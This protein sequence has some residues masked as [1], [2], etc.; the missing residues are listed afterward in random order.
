M[1]DTLIIEWKELS[2]H[3]MGNTPDRDQLAEIW[4]RKF[5][6]EKLLADELSCNV[7][8]NVLAMA[9]GLTPRQQVGEEYFNDLNKKLDHYLMLFG[10]Q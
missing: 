4:T 2:L 1:L 7:P 8:E 3:T 5:E 6:V 10:E 9:L